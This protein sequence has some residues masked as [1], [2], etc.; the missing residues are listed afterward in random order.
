MGK[1][2]REKNKRL[3]HD[4]QI[5]RDRRNSIK[6]DVAEFVNKDNAE[7]IYNILFVLKDTDNME[8]VFLTIQNM[9][10]GFFLSLPNIN[11]DSFDSSENSSIK[12]VIYNTFGIQ[13]DNIELI[14]KTRLIVV[15]NFTMKK[16][17]N[18]FTRVIVRPYSYYTWYRDNRVTTLNG[19]RIYSGKELKNYFRI[20]NTDKLFIY[21]DT[22]TK[23]ALYKVYERKV[24]PLDFFDTYNYYRYCKPNSHNRY[25]DKEYAIAYNKYL[26]LLAHE[27]DELKEFFEPEEMKQ[28]RL[29]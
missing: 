14:E 3:R 8:E 12:S 19:F 6:R 22:L 11:A 20:S 7:D 21:Q 26:K 25:Y 10:R 5:S 4:R 29:K 28:K 1:A 16:K 24:N 27:Q 2:R 13:S 18:N 23:L 15:K 9:D 17:L